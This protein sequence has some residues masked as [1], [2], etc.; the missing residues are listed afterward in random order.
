MTW[1]SPW[2]HQIIK[3]SSG[4]GIQKALL[5]VGH[6]KTSKNVWPLSETTEAFRI[7]RRVFF[8]YEESGA[9]SRKCVWWELTQ[10][11]THG[12]KPDLKRHAIQVGPVSLNEL[13]CCAKIA[14]EASTEANRGDDSMAETLRR[15]EQKL[16]VSDLHT[17][18]VRPISDSDSEDIP[19]PW[20]AS[21]GQNQSRSSQCK[22][23]LC[24]TS[25]AWSAGNRHQQVRFHHALD[26]ATSTWIKHI[27]HAYISSRHSHSLYNLNLYN[28]SRSNHGLLAIQPINN[29][30]DNKQAFQNASGLPTSFR[31][32]SNWSRWIFR[33]SC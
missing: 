21:S 28:H 9:T 12:L 13:L 18:E 16:S 17:N 24:R 29:S 7:G 10:R 1:E 8:W 30:T 31:S 15:I 19:R 2:C 22:V 25:L 4:G 5:P 32:C 20:S 6:R 23:S 26:L 33:R 27:N 14:K 3:V 11:H